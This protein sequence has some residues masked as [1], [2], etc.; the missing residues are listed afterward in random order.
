LSAEE[1]ARI[2]DFL[3]MDQTCRLPCWNG[4]T[5][6]ISGAGE[7]QGFFARLGIDMKNLVP[8][9]F[10]DDSLYMYTEFDSYPYGH[11]NLT[12]WVFMYW[13]DGIVKVIMIDGLDYSVFNMGRYAET[14]GIPDQIDYQVRNGGGYYLRL[15]YREYQTF[16]TISG[17][18][19]MG[20][21]I[22][23]PDKDSPWMKVDLFAREPEWEEMVLNMYG[24]YWVQWESKL[25]LTTEEIFDK[26]QEP[27]ICMPVD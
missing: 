12:P 4:V 18:T 26:L 19:I 2:G 9:V 17:K 27:G 21:S 7:L 10:D 11:K 25:N 15:Q 22:C 3:T 24:D 23:L 16:I 13:E 8:Q 5:P 20:E 14:L 6:G 1:A